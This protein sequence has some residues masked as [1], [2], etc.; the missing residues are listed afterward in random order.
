MVCLPVNLPN[1]SLNA[2]T[3]NCLSLSQIKDGVWGDCGYLHMP[4]SGEP[5]WLCGE[6]M[7]IPFLFQQVLKTQDFPAGIL[8]LYQFSQKSAFRLKKRKPRFHSE[9]QL[10]SISSSVMTNSSIVTNTSRG[11]PMLCNTLGVRMRSRESKEMREVLVA[12]AIGLGWVTVSCSQASIC[13]PL[14]ARAPLRNV[15]LPLIEALFAPSPCP[16]LD[17]CLKAIFPQFKNCWPF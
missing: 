1:E 9:Y 13:Q 17:L 8:C 2:E 6:C 4:S 15:P 14:G 7:K 11:C 3:P 5:I 16:A 12:V 10:H